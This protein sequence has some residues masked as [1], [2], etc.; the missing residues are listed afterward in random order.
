MLPYASAIASFSYF[1]FS[2]RLSLSPVIF[3]GSE[4]NSYVF[5]SEE[6][7]MNSGTSENAKEGTLRQH[8]VSLILLVPS[9]DGSFCSQKEVF[10]SSGFHSAT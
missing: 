9:G 5:H 1:F 7:E 3:T 2:L 10:A 4:E 8:I 6:C